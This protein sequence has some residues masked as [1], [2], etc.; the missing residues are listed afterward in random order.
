[1]VFVWTYRQISQMKKADTLPPLAQDILQWISSAETQAAIDSH[2][3]RPLLLRIFRYLYP[4]ILGV[5]ALWLVMFL[6]MALVLIVL[7]RLRIEK[8]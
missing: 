3:L 8:S 7:L 6:C 1:M 2:I 4:Y 5:M